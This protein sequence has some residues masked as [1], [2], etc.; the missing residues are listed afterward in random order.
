MMLIADSPE[1]RDILNTIQES[2]QNYQSLFQDELKSLKTG[3]DY[4]HHW[5][6]REKEKATQSIINE[7]EKLRTYTA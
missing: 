6:N 2:Y 1:T 5:F 4:S 3:Q 7:L